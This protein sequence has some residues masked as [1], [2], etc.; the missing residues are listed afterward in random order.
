MEG[1]IENGHRWEMNICVNCGLVKKMSN[2]PKRGQ[3]IYSND[4]FKTYQTRAGLC[5]TK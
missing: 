2:K 1:K 4:D 5:V 3:L